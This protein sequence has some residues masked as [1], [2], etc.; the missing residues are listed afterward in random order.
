M[1][2]GNEE[3]MI[4]GF[5]LGKVYPADL[6]EKELAMEGSVSIL[7][8]HTTISSKRVYSVKKGTKSTL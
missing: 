3:K 5:K 1:K 4:K 2:T 8:R 7:P 6:L